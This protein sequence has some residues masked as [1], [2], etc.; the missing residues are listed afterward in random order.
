MAAAVW[1]GAGIVVLLVGA[2]LTAGSNGWRQGSNVPVVLDGLALLWVTSGL[3]LFRRRARAWFGE[4]P[5]S[6]AI[7]AAA[8]LRSGSVRG[9]LELARDLPA[10]VSLS[11]AT[12]AAERTVADLQGLP[13]MA[14]TGDLGERVTTWTRR[15][16]GVLGV[17][18][19][20]LV[21]LAVLAPGRTSGALAGLSS[22]FR[23]MIDPVLPAIV[24]EPGDLEVL[25][26]SDVQLEVRALGR[27]EVVLAWQAAG[28]V[29]RSETLGVLEGQASHVFRSVSAPIDYRVRDD[30]GNESASF[31]IVPIDPLFVSDLVI[32]VEYPPHTGL[33]PDEYRGDPPRMRLPAGTVLS[34]EGRS[35]RPLSRAALVDTTETQ[36]LDLTPQGLMF[37]GVWT[38]RRGGTFDWV[39]LDEAGEPAEIQPVPLTISL[40]PDSIPTVQIPLP[41][42]DT[43][44]SLSLQQPLILDARDDYGLR[45]LE[46]V[47]YRVTSLGD[48]H[49]P[50]V[51]AL[52]LGGARAALA[53]PI[54]DVASWGLLPGD[55]VRYF[56]RVVDNSPSAQTGISREFVLRMPAAAELRRQAETALGEAADQLEELASEAARQAEQNMDQAR[57]TAAQR[58][59]Q[60]PARQAQSDF[61]Q[62]EG[63]QQALDD[64]TELAQAVDSLGQELDALERM[65][66]EAGQADPQ[67]RNQLDE[68][69]ELLDELNNDDLQDRMEDLESALER[70]NLRDANR[71][72]EEL[73][74]AQEDLRDRLKES[75]ERFRRA[76]V[77]QD[78][79][80]TTS[81]AEELALQEQALADAMAE[82]D[83][84][85]LRAEQQDALAD[86][87]GE[88]QERMENLEERLQE[89]GER[90]AAEGVQEAMQRASEARESMQEAR[91]Q[92]AQD[93]EQAGREA[94]QAAQQMEDAAR[95]LQNAQQQMAQ[96]KMEAQEQALRQAAD[97]ALSLARQQSELRQEM[98]GASQEELAGMRADEAS[99]LQGVENVA[100]NL[101]LATQ[102]ELQG[103]REISAQMGRA[104]EAIEGTLE[105][106][107]AR[108]SSSGSPYGQAQEVV[109]AL[110]GL[111]LMAIAGA[112][113]LGQQGPGQ[114]GQEVGEQLE[115]LAQQQG[116]LM[117]QTGQIVPMQ[118]GQQAMSQQLQD[119]SQG[120]QSV[121]DNLGDLAEDPSSQEALGD[122]AEMALEA[123][124]LA[125]ELAQGRLTPEMMRR[126]ER[127]FHRLLD[128][129]R[130]LERE[131]FSEERES[132]EPGAFDRVDVLPLSAAQMG[133][134][135]YELPDGEQLQRLSPAVRQLVL[136]YFERLNRERPTGGG[137]G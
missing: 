51:Q 65:L 134:M 23:T 79:R 116:D 114:S 82:E 42:A 44:L 125:Q 55:N 9:P 14:L 66:Q 76:A 53:R 35:S 119:L 71:S 5:L 100:E 22:P 96:Q 1:M 106:M 12:R 98:R 4:A 68:L 102:G 10:G 18:G 117:N 97:D 120:Q 11:L 60:D 123:E 13:T 115:E 95:E 112:E 109:G 8:G 113:Q 38:P 2:W 84:P 52:E 46:L 85:E 90:D 15:G 110:N 56:A 135:P 104:M 17:L 129:G 74:A 59:A 105:S 89:L 103:D 40:L 128:A 21:A 61:E 78:F 75:L 49:D 31:R 72:L 130:S 48:R 37:E 34:F 7:E 70:D 91:E 27:L 39:F 124:A 80:A 108:R 83:N 50:V 86:R 67:L 132:E 41:G 121:S 3:L 73:A 36:A 69:Q 126:Q 88:L 99:L 30:L 92:A 45:S 118:L 29:A 93:G 131:E 64:Q 43:V 16:L 6:A 107:G 26:G 20:V 111:A 81:E 122:L 28:D 47:A 19:F 137:P 25:R 62:R 54:L 87:T 32:R 94:D 24:V 77:E 58:D 63:L 33:P 127:L 57:E 136:D 133:V 101:Q